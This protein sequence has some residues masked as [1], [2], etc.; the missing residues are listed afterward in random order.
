MLS[1]TT[2]LTYVPRH[3]RLQVNSAWCCVLVV[4]LPIGCPTKKEESPV[5]TPATTPANPAL[6]SVT[7]PFGNQRRIQSTT[8]SATYVADSVA[9]IRRYTS[10]Q[11]ESCGC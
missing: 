1:R 6:H 10:S 4:S 11:S 7:W 9:H 2:A 5:R 8:S 3:T